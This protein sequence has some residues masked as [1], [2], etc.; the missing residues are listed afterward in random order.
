MLVAVVSEFVFCHS[1]VDN[2]DCETF[3][4][5]RAKIFVSAIAL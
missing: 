4:I 5:M 2:V 3:T 1:S